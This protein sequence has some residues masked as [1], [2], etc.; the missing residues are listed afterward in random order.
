MENLRISLTFL[1][2]YNIILTCCC[3]KANSRWLLN[4]VDADLDELSFNSVW[5]ILSLATAVST[6]VFVRRPWSVPNIWFY[7]SYMKFC[8]CFLQVFFLAQVILYLPR[9]IFDFL[10]QYFTSFFFQGANKGRKRHSPT[11]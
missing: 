2:R 7:C 11:L 9:F 6:A 5:P 3:F 10:Y 1:L 8:V 4:C